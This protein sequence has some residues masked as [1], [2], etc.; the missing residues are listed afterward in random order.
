MYT[1]KILCISTVVF[2]LIS[3][4]THAAKT[5]VNWSHPEKYR[6]IDAGN[7]NRAAFKKH[8]FATMDKFIAKLAKDLPAQQ[9]LK[10]KVTDLDLAGDTH[11]AF[12]S[13]SDQIR[14][15]KDIYFPRIKFSYQLVD[16]NDH[17]IKSD[18]VNLKDMNFMLTNNLRY[19]NEPF[20]YDKKMLSDWFKTTFKN[21]LISK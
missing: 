8:L 17:I 9:T 1:Y 6:D 2:C 7:H 19:R 20:G 12:T 14:V 21:D 5:E 11:D 13:L 15:V 3:P 18:D 16:E 4:Q 10:I